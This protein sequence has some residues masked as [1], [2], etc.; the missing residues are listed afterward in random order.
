MLI[1]ISDKFDDTL[2]KLLTKHG[3]VTDD[4]NRY[5]EAE[6]ILVRSKTQVTREYIDSAP[7]LKLVIRGGVGLDNIDVAYADEKGIK[8]LNTAEASTVAVA[9]L[10]FTLI[11][12]ITN[13][14]AR[15]DKSMREGKWIKKELNRTELMGKTLAIL[16]LGRIGTALAI[17]A[18]AFRMKIL[19]WRPDT[20]FSDFAEIRSDLH[21]TLNE[22]DY[23]S[24]HMPLIPATRGIINKENLSHFKDGAYL[25]N[26][27]RGACVVEEDIVDALKSGKLGGYATDV[28]KSDPPAPD[29]PLLTAPNTLLMPHIGASSVENMQR[30]AMIAEMQIEQHLKGK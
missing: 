3:E 29:C 30:I 6:V 23:V 15:A 21:S 11:I 13:H 1:L 28:W 12:S 4:K 7:Q 2:P 27:G 20:H 26:T 14:V 8:V 17:R 19:G 24:M 22:A 10:A 25:V 9:E 5:S 18:R 16:G